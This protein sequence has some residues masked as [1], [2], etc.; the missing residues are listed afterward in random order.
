MWSTVGQD[1][2][3]SQ[4]TA[5]LSDDRLA[6]AYLFIGPASVGKMCLAIDLAK[7]VNCLDNGPDPCGECN[8]CIRITR[9]HHADVRIVSIV[10]KDSDRPTRTVIGIDDVK[11]ILHQ[12]NLKPFEGLCTVI[13]FD[14]AENLSQEASNALLKTLEEPSPQ[15][16]IILLTNSEETILETI[17]S[18]CRSYRLRTSSKEAMQSFLIDGYSSDRDQCEMIARISRGCVGWAIRAVTDTQVLQQREADLDHILDTMKSGLYEKFNYANEM[19]LEFGRD[20]TA[21]KEVLYL[22][23]SWWRDLL[24]VKNVGE[25]H[26]LSLDRL[27]T[28]TDQSFQLTT[29]DIV[30]FVKLIDHTLFA[31]NHNA[32]TRVSFENLMIN[33]PK[34]T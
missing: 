15:V 34:I 29:D 26:V 13:I 30:Q 19:A 11:D 14:G 33:M 31:L 23:K 6:H 17:L 3:L 24:L 9:G 18:R 4:L 1:H 27:G 2:I 7:A 28:L 22:W 12:T 8:Q 16:L 25:G 5:S 32:N 10:E 20:R 21:V